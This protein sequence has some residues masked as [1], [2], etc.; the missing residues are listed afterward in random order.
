MLCA[1]F[2]QIEFYKTDIIFIQ[3]Y[4]PPPPTL[5]QI[6]G[7]GALLSHAKYASVKSK[8]SHTC[9]PAFLGSRG[10]LVLNACLAD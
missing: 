6:A 5:A 9:S 4:P 8:I 1:R 3:D 7:C 10:I 2:A